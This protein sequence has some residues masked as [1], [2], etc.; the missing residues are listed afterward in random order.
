MLGMTVFND[1]YLRH[2]GIPGIL[3]KKCHIM[4]QTCLNI[5]QIVIKPSSKNRPISQNTNDGTVWEYKMR[6]ISQLCSIRC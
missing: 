1:P 6:P 4:P 2:N 3:D 5:S